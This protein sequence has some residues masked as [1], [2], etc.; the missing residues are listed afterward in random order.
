MKIPVTPGHSD[1]G[2]NARRVIEVTV[3]KKRPVSLKR[4]AG[5][6]LL[7]LLSSVPKDQQG[8]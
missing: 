4:A 3:P 8:D 1:G 6:L 2:L 7:V 5:W